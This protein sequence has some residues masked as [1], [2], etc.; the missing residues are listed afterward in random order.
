MIDL[1]LMEQK[2]GQSAQWNIYDSGLVS[3]CIHS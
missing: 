3:A 1:K 2:K